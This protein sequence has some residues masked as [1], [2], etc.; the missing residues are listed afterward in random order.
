MQLQT[1]IK[2]LNQNIHLIW[3]KVDISSAACGN[4][5]FDGASVGI[6]Q[7]HSLAVGNACAAF[8][9][10][11]VAKEND[12]CVL[13]LS[14]AGVDITVVAGNDFPK[15]LSPYS[16]VVHCGGCMFG[17]RQ[18]LSR[19]SRAVR[20]GVPITNYGILIAEMTDILDSVTL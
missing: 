10:G 1:N 9:V 2:L 4:K 7:L 12:L 19:I 17:R 13:S 5:L 3:V 6:H 8:T 11:I 16:L 20:Q 18:I 14:L 15:D